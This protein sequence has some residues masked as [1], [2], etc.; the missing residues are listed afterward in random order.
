[1][2]NTSDTEAIARRLV[3]VFEREADIA[4]GFSK[5][6]N[7]SMAQA[8]EAA[9]LG[10]LLRLVLT[11]IGSDVGLRLDIDMVSVFDERPTSARVLDGCI[12]VGRSDG[13]SIA[14]ALVSLLTCNYPSAPGFAIAADE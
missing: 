4:F 10:C 5:T 1:M 13:G 2:S 6:D 14:N 11:A 12:S 9:A 3:V 8:H 7:P